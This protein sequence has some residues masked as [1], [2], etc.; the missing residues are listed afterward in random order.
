L[1]Q[2][3]LDVCL[4]LRAPEAATPLLEPLGLTAIQAPLSHIPARPDLAG[5]RVSCY[6]DLLVRYSLDQEPR[7]LAL[8]RA[9]DDLLDGWRP[10]LVVGDF[11]PVL[12]LAARGRLPVV[13]VGSG[14]TVP[15]AGEPC[16][17]K[18]RDLPSWAPEAEL[19]ETFMPCNGN[20]IGPCWAG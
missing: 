8:T 6:A 10:D 7:L 15:P 20:A 11:A 19:L 14:Y 4:A 13:H 3:G 9:W 17:P 18:L 12:A 5:L 16:F 2:R 1:R